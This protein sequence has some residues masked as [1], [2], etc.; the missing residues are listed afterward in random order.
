MV[1]PTDA[2]IAAIEKTGTLHLKAGR[3]PGGVVCQTC[4][5][6]HRLPDTALTDQTVSH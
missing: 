5:A 4:W 1:G 2:W 3:M 6:G